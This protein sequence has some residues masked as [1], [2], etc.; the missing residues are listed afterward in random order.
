MGASGLSASEGA[1][2]GSEAR[3]GAPEPGWAQVRVPQSVALESMNV[4]CAVQGIAEAPSRG[5]GRARPV[6][7]TGRTV[8]QARF[9]TDSQFRIA[10]LFATGISADRAIH[11]AGS[12]VALCLWRA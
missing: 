9:R 5:E 10:A 7:P 11:T 4:G 8:D 12:R 3:R 2:G 1:R 6:V